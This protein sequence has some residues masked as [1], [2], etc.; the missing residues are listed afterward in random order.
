MKNH[1]TSNIL[2]NQG[3]APQDLSRVHRTRSW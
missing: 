3:A 2:T 1:N